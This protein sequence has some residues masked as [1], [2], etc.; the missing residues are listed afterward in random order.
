M[1]GCIGYRNHLLGHD[2][3]RSV[4]LSGALVLVVAIDNRC[5]LTVAVPGGPHEGLWSVEGTGSSLFTVCLVDDH[6][7][8]HLPVR[9]QAK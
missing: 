9:E 3:I 6:R 7:A 1:P 5:R 8:R 2:G 4:F